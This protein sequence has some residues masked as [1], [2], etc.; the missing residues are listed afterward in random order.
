[1]K[2]ICPSLK[3]FDKKVLVLG[4][5]KS[6]IS[7]AKYLNKTGADVYL[8]EFR[9]EKP[10]DAEILKELRAS[11]IK[12]EMGGH[13]DDFIKDHK[14][15]Y[16]M[17]NKT[18]NLYELAGLIKKS[19]RII[20]PDS[21]P[22]HIAVSLGADITV[23]FGPTNEKKLVPEKENIKVVTKNISCR[24]CLWDKRLTNC[25]NSECIGFLPEDVLNYMK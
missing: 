10:E 21:A 2:S 1:M 5:S 23:L 13:S 4:L 18:K 24:P 12:I 25:E 9:E 11:G 3:L 19:K 22:L 14:N 20:C 15:F 8:T 17:F 6:G 7:A 16:S